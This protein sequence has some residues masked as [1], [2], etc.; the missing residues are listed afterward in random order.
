HMRKRVQANPEYFKE[1]AAKVRPLAGAWH[2]SKEG[3]EWHKQHAANI[4]FGKRKYGQRK[5]EVCSN[6]FEA[7]NA[8][9]RFCSNK[10]KSQFRRKS[11]VD[12]II[13]PCTVCGSPF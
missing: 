9:Q 12:N 7:G 2:G 13:K 4:G 5:C 8:G 11:G 6:E 10:C 1:Q 3:I